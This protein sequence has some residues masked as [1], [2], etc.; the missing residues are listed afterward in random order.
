MA[1][2]GDRSVVLA[3]LQVAVLGKC[4]DQRLGP[5]GLPFSCLSDL[6]ADCR[7]SSDWTSSAGMLSTPADFSFF[8][9]CTA[10]STS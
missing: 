1:D 3:V 10:A 5:R 2:E 6:V 9:D 4:D 7:E 8:N